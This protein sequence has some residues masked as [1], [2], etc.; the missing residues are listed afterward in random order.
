MDFGCYCV[1]TGSHRTAVL[2][3][4]AE[5][6][7]KKANSAV[8]Q[9]CDSVYSQNK[10][11]IR[12]THTFCSTLVGFNSP[13]RQQS[14]RRTASD[15]KWLVAN[16]CSMSASW[17]SLNEKRLPSLFITEVRGSAPG[18][19]FQTGFQFLTRGPHWLNQVQIWHDWIVHIGMAVEPPRPLECSGDFRSYC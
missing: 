2:D 11:N 1:I 9:L 15:P 5:T 16:D 12:I 3:D 17:V 10:C 6:K 13:R 14:S 19:Q 18:A 4:E 7:W 8:T